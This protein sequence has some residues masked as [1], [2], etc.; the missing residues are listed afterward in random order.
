MFRM[1]SLGRL[2]AVSSIVFTAACAAQMPN[3][4]T[5]LDANRSLGAPKTY[6]NLTL[7]P[8]YDSSAKPGSAYITLDEGIKQSADAGATPVA[9]QEIGD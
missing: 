1:K 5:R 6:K 7:I 3:S 4:R 9:D 8:V 2:A